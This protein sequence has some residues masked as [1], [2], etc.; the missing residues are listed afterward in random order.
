M[1]MPMSASRS[2]GPSLTPSPVIATTWP[3]RCSARA[4]RSLSS[5]VDPGDH[6]AVAVEQRAERLRRRRAGRRPRAPRPSTSEQPDLAGDR[7][8]R[9][10]VVAGDHRHPD[11]GAPA[12]GDRRRRRSGRGGSSRPT[13]PSSSRSCS[14]SSAERRPPAIRRPVGGDGQHPQPA[15]GHRLAAPRSRASARRVQR[16]STR[17]GRALDE[18]PVADDDRHAPAP[19][20]EREPARTGRRLRR[21][22]RRR[23]AGG[24]G[25]RAPPP[26]GRRA[27]TQL[28]V[29]LHGAA[30]RAA[31]R[32]PVPSGA[33]SRHGR[34]GRD[35]R[36]GR[37][38]AVAGDAAPCPPA[39]TPRR[40]SSRCG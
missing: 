25:R 16:A 37:V 22:R 12:G 2:A 4:M 13:R 23:R 33:S 5:G 40:R 14:T 31:Q 7:P 32:R 19:R 38:V 11:A 35:E 1:A 17:V 21:R 34:R 18:Q 36:R 9:G 27:A 28:A 15:A 39:S 26:S 3:R 30:G 20:V 24:R 8:R 10:R 6:D 29:A